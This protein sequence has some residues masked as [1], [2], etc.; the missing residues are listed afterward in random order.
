MAEQEKV[1]AL[2]EGETTSAHAFITRKNSLVLTF[3]T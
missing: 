1:A 3:K 2:K